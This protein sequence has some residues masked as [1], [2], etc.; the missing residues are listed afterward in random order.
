MRNLKYA[1]K[2]NA[3]AMPLQN[4]FQSRDIE[5]AHKEN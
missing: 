2:D 4:E 3:S 5:E 1:L